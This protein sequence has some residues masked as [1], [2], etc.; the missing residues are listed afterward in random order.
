MSH[1]PLKCGRAENGKGV[2]KQAW[3]VD[4]SHPPNCVLAVLM[5]SKVL[6]FVWVGR[7]LY[8]SLLPR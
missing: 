1:Y 4:L 8:C 5:H 6:K 3:N 2:I 7:A